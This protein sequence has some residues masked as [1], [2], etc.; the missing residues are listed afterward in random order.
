MKYISSLGDVLGSCGQFLAD[1]LLESVNNFL[2]VGS[3]G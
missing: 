2:L 3:I 1:V